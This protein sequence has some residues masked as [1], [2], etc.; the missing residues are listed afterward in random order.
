MDVNLTLVVSEQVRSG[1]TVTLVREGNRHHSYVAARDVAAFAVAAIGH[2]G[3]LNQ[4]IAIGG[5]AAL[6]WRAV[7]ATYERVLGRSITVSWINPGERI[8]NLP[9]V[10][11]LTE[12]VS[13]LLAWL[14]TFDSVV[15][16]A[17]TARTF[18]VTQT[19]VEEFI[20]DAMTH[21]ESP[22]MRA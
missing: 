22:S 11:G 21:G 8:P 19:S 13:G 4:R 18:G 9:P 15:D 10:P 20:V 14:E 16:M 5:P 2:P 1:R 12:L 17:Q 3:A 7:I 6:S